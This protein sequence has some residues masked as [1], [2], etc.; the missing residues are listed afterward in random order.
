MFCH[1]KVKTGVPVGK[2]L[3]LKRGFRGGGWR[4]GQVLKKTNGKKHEFVTCRGVFEHQKIDILRFPH[5]ILNKNLIFH[6]Y[7]RPI[8]H[9]QKG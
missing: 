3:L 2:G 5:K 8:T 6:R 7:I 9:F 1:R 4:K